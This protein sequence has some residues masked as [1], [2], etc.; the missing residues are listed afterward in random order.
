M[1]I[2][3]Q[4][5]DPA[6]RINGFEGVGP[7]WLLPKKKE[8]LFTFCKRVRFEVEERETDLPV[9]AYCITSTSSLIFS[10]FF[11]V[12]FLLFFFSSFYS[13]FLSTP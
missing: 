5:K 7:K 8:S 6:V 3:S 4:E 13:I 12:F 11:S 1:Q 9:H 10:L 2:I